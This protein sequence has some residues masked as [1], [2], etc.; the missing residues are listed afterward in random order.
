MK[1]T[2]NVRMPQGDKAVLIAAAAARGESV[3]EF[4]RRTTVDT[5][6]NE[7]EGDI[8]DPSEETQ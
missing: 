7:L 8:E 1:E 6:L 2:L 4:V 5:A 3:S